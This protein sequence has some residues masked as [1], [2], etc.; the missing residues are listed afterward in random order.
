M[1]TDKVVEIVEEL[2][3]DYLIHIENYA[4]EIME[5]VSAYCETHESGEDVKHMVLCYASQIAVN[6]VEFVFSIHILDQKKC[7]SARA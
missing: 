4:K 1:K 6:S 7:D 2:T 3:Q 5:K